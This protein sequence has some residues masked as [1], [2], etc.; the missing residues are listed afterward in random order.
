MQPEYI[1]QA[2]KAEDHVMKLLRKNGWTVVHNNGSLRELLATPFKVPEEIKKG[3]N[4]DAQKYLNDLFI[5]LK[6]RFKY[7]KCN[8]FDFIARKGNTTIMAEVKAKTGKD[9]EIDVPYYNIYREFDTVIPFLIFFYRK[10][11][12]R[13]AMTRNPKTEP[14]YPTHGAHDKM[15]NVYTIHKNET[16][17]LTEWLKKDCSLEELRKLLPK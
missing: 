16:M 9:L 7:M 4:E 2:A 5:T 11:K 17:D 13:V 14:I 3:M 15:E 12:I 8:K 6:T 1:E 10:R